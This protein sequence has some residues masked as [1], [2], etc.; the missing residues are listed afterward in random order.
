[1]EGTLRLQAQLAT[2]DRQ[3]RL[4][5]TPQAQQE[6]R[7]LLEGFLSHR[8][9]PISRPAELAQRM[10]RLAHLIRAI[11]VEA[12][13]RQQASPLLRD[14][15]H[16]FREV[17]LPDLTE[18]AFA[19]MFA[20]TLTYGLFAARFH[21]RGAQ[22]FRRTDAAREIPRTNP[23]LRRL[24]GAITGVEL[25]DEPF[26]GFV[27]ELAELLALTPCTRS[28]EI[29]L[30]TSLVSSLAFSVN[31]FQRWLRE[32]QKGHGSLG[33]SPTTRYTIPSV[34]CSSSPAQNRQGRG[35][36]ISLWRRRPLSQGSREQMPGSRSG[37]IQASNL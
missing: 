20:Q 4:T 17:L 28:R 31:W 21:H 8:A 10:A 37:L 5:T 14:L 24:F 16:S 18:A 30:L 15:Y 12:F 29:K 34:I 6:V 36:S 32:M 26:V 3:R 33:K 27:D 25:D 19:D 11:V 2:I 13:Q 22:P 9:A 35:N 23:F 7:A 1:M